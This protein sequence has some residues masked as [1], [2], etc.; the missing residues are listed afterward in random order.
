[1]ARGKH[2]GGIPPILPGQSSKAIGLRL[3][4]SQYDELMRAVADT[5]SKPTVLVRQALLE[6]LERRRPD[7]GLGDAA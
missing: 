1:M 7:S 6:F 4:A 5:G 3:A 2:S